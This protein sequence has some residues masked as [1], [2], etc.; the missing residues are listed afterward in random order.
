[1]AMP[2][3]R[4]DIRFEFMNGKV[5]KIRIDNGEQ[6]WPSPPAVKTCRTFHTA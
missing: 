3:K 1:M 4:K 6:G 2:S 5:T